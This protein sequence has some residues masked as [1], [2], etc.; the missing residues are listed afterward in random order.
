VSKDV[1]CRVCFY[2]AEKC[3]KM[4]NAGFAVEIWKSSRLMHVVM[5]RGENS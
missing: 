4:S 3:Q 1:K 5:E 2:K